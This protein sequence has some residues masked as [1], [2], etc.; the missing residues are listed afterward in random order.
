MK[1]VLQGFLCLS[2]VVLG[3]CD[4][5]SASPPGVPAGGVLGVVNV[6]QTLPTYRLESGAEAAQLAYAAGSR[7][8]LVG[9][10]WRDLEPTPGTFALDALTQEVAYAK[11]LGFTVL[12]NLQVINTSACETP[13]DLET[14]AFDE[15]P[16]QARFRVL[17]D[18]LAQTLGQDVTYLAIGNEVDGYLEVSGTWE[19]Y[20]RFYADSVKNVSGADGRDNRE[21]RG[22][23]GR[24]AFQSKS[25]GCRGRRRHLYLLSRR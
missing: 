4:D 7:G 15:A 14:F 9:F 24:C 17:L 22:A 16:V 23:L 12:L 3:G 8:Y 6:P 5:A 13:D 2:A 11:A 25:A 19:T 20:T 1:R 21:C 10:T 18:A